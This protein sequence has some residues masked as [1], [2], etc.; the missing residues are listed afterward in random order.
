[1][2]EKQLLLAGLCLAGVAARTLYEVLKKRGL[3]DTRRVGALVGLMAAMTAF[4][5]SWIFMGPFEPVPLSWAAAQWAGLGL[6][7]AG[8]G[9]AVCGLA[10]LG[11]PENVDHLVTG[12]VFRRL[13]H[14]MY[15][16]FVFWIAGWVL[17]HGAVAS[18]PIALVC[19]G[20]VLYWR[21]LEERALEARYGEDFRRYRQRTWF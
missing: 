2:L 3:I 16:G 5:M 4:L 19:I 11:R 7:V 9:L 10:Q 18:V 13:R 12:G 8:F 6:V 14:P 17:F 15:T 20:N 1:M 21:R